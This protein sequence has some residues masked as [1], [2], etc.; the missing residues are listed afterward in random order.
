MND[1]SDSLLGAWTR[2]TA[3]KS[4]DVP[5]SS[6]WR[7]DV[8]PQ[9]LAAQQQ[10]LGRDQAAVEIAAERLTIFIDAWQ[11]T[12]T[13]IS[14]K[15]LDGMTPED[16]LRLALAGI[17]GVQP[18]DLFDP[19]AGAK[20]EFDAFVEQVRELTSTYA[21]IDTASSGSAVASTRIGWTGD[22]QTAWH[23][24][25][26][27]EQIAFHRE[28]VR[29]AL[30]RRAMVIR[31]MTI[32]STGAVKIIIRLATPGAQLLVLPALWQ[33]VQDVVAQIRILQSQP[34]AS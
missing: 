10:A 21:R 29:I 3:T 28:N 4:L 2:S 20:A 9:T 5:H 14:S 34:E 23:D 7:L 22:F 30:A 11:L 24:H 1:I 16:D 12:T 33:F 25:L 31:L 18:K 17:N 19:L 27:V 13:A 8:A 15:S 26:T 6:E 32:I